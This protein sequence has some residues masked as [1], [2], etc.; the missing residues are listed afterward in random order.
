MNNSVFEKTV[1]NLRERI[2]VKLINNAKDYV[3]FASKP[4]FVSQE[5]SSKAFAAV[6][7]MKLN[8]Y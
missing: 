1:E 2:N 5:I 4:N 8:N 6:C 3:R 7:I